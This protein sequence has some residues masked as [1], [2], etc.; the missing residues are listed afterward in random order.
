VLHCF[1]KKIQKGHQNA[2]ERYRPDQDGAAI[3]GAGAPKMNRISKS[4]GNVFADVGLP[5]SETLLAKAKLTSK[6]ADAMTAL[7][8]PQ[9]E[10]AMRIGLPQPKISDLL[11]GR[12]HGFSM[13]RLFRILNA[14]G[15]DVRIKTAPA[16]QHRARL[17]VG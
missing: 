3:C 2:E 17:A 16:K 6:I 10:V 15:Q 9:A 12:F 4:S 11:H 7:D 1:Q 8:L 13:D 5:D 14:L